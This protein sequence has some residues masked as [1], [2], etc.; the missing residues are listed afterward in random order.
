MEAQRYP[1]DFDGIVAGAPAH[2]WQ[3]IAAVGVQINQKMFP[4][5]SFL[6]EAIIG[7]AEQALIRTTLP[8]AM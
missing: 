8:G 7:E 3:A 6:D 1:K 5:P 4:D 2:N